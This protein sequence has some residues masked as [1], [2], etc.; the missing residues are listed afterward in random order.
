MIVWTYCRL[1][2]LESALL[3]D[4]N[5]NEI[6]SICQGKTIPE[7]LRPDVWQLCLDVRHASDQMAAFNEIF[8]LPFQQTLR[9]DC[10]TFVEKLGNDDDE[11]VSVVSD[12]ESILTFY[13]KNRQLPYETGNGWVELL[14]PLLSLKL[15]RSYTYNMFE[16]IRDSYIPR[17]CVKKGNVFHVFRLLIFYHDPELCSLL[18]TKRISADLYAMSW[19]QSLFAATCSFPVVLAMWDQYF[20]HSDPF[21]VFFL[22]LIMLI[23]GRDQ[24]LAMKV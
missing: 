21:L 7:S 13:C 4:C 11:R 16:A 19:F 5:V 20:Q 2:E 9:Q 17:G 3:D 22:S 12:L 8:D 24:I 23:N 10:D 18:D 14:L 1:I 15:S 6:F